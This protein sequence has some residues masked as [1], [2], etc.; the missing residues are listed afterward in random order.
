[1][2]RLN[3]WEKNPVEVNHCQMYARKDSVRIIAMYKM[4]AS[5]EDAATC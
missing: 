2:H 1:M 5:R 4:P 3:V